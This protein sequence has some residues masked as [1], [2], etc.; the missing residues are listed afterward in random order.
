MT[1]VQH[2]NELENESTDVL[3]PRERSRRRLIFGAVVGVI[4]L[5]AVGAGV[6]AV[7]TGALADTGHDAPQQQFATEQVVRGDLEES[8]SATG[9]LR[10]DDSRAVQAGAA[11][12]VTGLPSPG[13]TVSAGESLYSIDDAPV[14]LLRGEIPTW[15]GFASGM[16]DGADVQQLEEALRELGFF[17]DEPDELFRWATVEAIMDWQE[18]H[19]LER[20]GELPFGS[21][22]FAEGDLR[23]GTLTASVGD[24]IAAGSEL[25]QASSTTQ[26]VEVD[27]GLADQQLA[28]L[29]AAVIVR[30]PG[31]ENTSG[32]IV[33]VG[34]PTETESGTGEATTVI[35]VVVALDDADAAS[36]FQEA[37]VTVDIPSQ[38][39]EDVLSVP[40]GALLAITPDQFGVELVEPDGSTRQVPV[41]TGLFAGG[42]VEIAGDGIAEGAEVVVPQR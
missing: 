30:L 42:R 32:T 8:T 38:S 1:A 22:V 16:G 6:W 34:T 19:G 13:T 17:A 12:T 10:Y 5:G 11:G 20:T 31:G 2:E 9:T 29:D 26:I 23:I 35:P 39:R 36:A 37:S 28:V 27:L 15:R 40:V 25:F 18:S 41:E 3:P 33:S 24:Q 14:F 21:V 7:S 4:L